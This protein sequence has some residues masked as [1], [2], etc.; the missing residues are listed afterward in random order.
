MGQVIYWVALAFVRILQALPLRTVARLGRC[1]GA[2]A[3]CL[4]VRH[5]KVA[6][7]NLAMCF[8]KEKSPAEIRAIARENF[9]RIGEN[10][11]CAIK[12][13]AMTSEELRPHLEFVGG[14]RLYPE[15]FDKH[16][17]RRVVA[18]GHF[19]NFELYARVGDFFPGVQAA[20]TYRALRPARLNDLL[21]EIRRRSRSLYFERRTEADALK[22]AMSQPGILLGLLADQHGGQ[23]GIWG[24]FFG[25]EC[26]TGAASA[27]Y[28]LRYHCKL[29]VGFCFR[30]A[31]AQWRM[32][33]GEEIPTHANGH[34]RPVAAITADINRSFEAAIRR[35]PANWFWVHRRW[36][37]RL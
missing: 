25:K 27:L 24:P 10:Y 14:N 9:R 34:P 3:Y 35:D 15:P 19:G 22:A 17:P 28:A 33:L 36:K 7:D 29:F 5:R 31:L 1:G 37:P 4:D 6:L 16:P 23:K 8:E 18:I 2:L 30:T 12:T 26:S 32:E 13:A 20:T 11:C 21:L